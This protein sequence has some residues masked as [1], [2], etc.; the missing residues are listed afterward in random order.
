[1]TLITRIFADRGVNVWYISIYQKHKLCEI[2]CYQ[3]HPRSK[4]F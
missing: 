1:M 4:N 2:P 3:R